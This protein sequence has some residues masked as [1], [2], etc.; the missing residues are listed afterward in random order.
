MKIE[1]FLAALRHSMTSMG[2]FVVHG[3]WAEQSNWD[4]VSLAVVTMVGFGW[5]IWRKYH[6][7]QRA[8]A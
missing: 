4:E 1:I 7:T 6:R 3:G 2:V 8:G 5:S